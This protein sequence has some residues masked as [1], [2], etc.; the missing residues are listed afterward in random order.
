MD[1]SEK[2]Y[3]LRSE[4]G[5]SQK[6]FGQKIGASQSAVY[7]WE[8][9][10]RTPKLEQ[11][12]KIAKAL[13]L[14]VTDL[15]DVVEYS[16]EESDKLTKQTGYATR[17]LPSYRYDKLLDRFDELNENGQDKVIEQAEL[18]IKIPEYRKIKKDSDPKRSTLMA[19]HNDHADDPEEQ[20][21]IQRDL[22]MMKKIDG[23][24]K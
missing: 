18:L 8:T 1:I 14:P 24:E 10:G 23:Q 21:K 20:E 7:Y 22:D 11:I 15:I 5:L 13:G 16:L 19:A 3:K 6:E 4:L 2:L 9:G 17:I 12:Q